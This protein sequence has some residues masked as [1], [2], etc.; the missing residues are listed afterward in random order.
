MVKARGYLCDDFESYPVRYVVG[1]NLFILLYFGVGLTGTLPLKVLGFPVVTIGYVLFLFIMLIFVLRKHLCTNCYY[2]G[3]LC[4]T[5]WSKLASILFERGSGNYELGVKL[6][7]ITWM[8][9][10]LIPIIGGSLALFLRFSTYQLTLLLTFVLLT[11]V[12]FTMHKKMCE[13]CKMRLSC[14][15]SM[16]KGD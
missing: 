1:Q 8:L 9:A 2:Y 10:T 16:A 5:G 15:V 7:S 6:A 12:N 14:Q 4:G 3:K 13:K 11:P